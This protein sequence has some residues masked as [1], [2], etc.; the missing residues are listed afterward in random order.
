MDGVLAVSQVTA[1]FYVECG[2]IS[3]D[4]GDGS[5][6]CFISLSVTLVSRRAEELPP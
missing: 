2:S 3:S 5:F 4:D 1:I 6:I